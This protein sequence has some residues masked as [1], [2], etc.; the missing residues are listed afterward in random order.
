M[1]AFSLPC[2]ALADT[3]AASTQVMD[4]TEK[5]VASDDEKSGRSFVVLPIPL[6]N[7]ALGSGLVVAGVAFYQ[8]EGSPR[9]WISG[10]GV[11]WTD[12]G[13]R[14]AGIFQKSYLQGDRYR[15]SAF[16]GGADLNL[17]FYGVGALDAG[18]DFSI[19]IKQ[20]GRALQVDGYRKL[21]ENLYVGLRLRTAEIT[22]SLRFEGDIPDF[23][24]EH[25]LEAQ[26]DISGPGL[27]AQYDSR[28]SELWP[29]TG[30]YG[31][32]EAQWSLD[33]FGSDYDYDRQVLS[34]NRYLSLSPSGVLALRGT[35]CRS[36]DGAPFFDLCLFGASNDLRGYES[37]QYRDHAMA[38]VQ[39]EY[40]W[41]FA[42]RW[43]AVFF[44]GVGGVAPSV[45]DLAEARTLPAGGVGLRF[46]ASKSYPVNISVDYA[47]GRDS[48]AVYFYIGEAF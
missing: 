6:S 34:Y 40:R 25:P 1:A 26:A 11:L 15:V 21:R 10:A 4:Q 33:A 29:T 8:P 31:N 13:S 9:P 27:L 22:T 42:S 17:K 36:G 18:R 48:E 19:P 41:K 16:L 3:G 47:V 23:L 30:S 7:P 43:G 38:A 32:L 12:N 37:G 39:A 14:G 20:E 45:G 44:A 2:L 35:L 24:E 5:A 28:D 46:R